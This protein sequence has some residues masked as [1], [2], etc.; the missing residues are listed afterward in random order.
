M[1]KNSVFSPVAA[2]FDN[3]GSGWLSYKIRRENFVGRQNF[4]CVKPLGFRNYAFI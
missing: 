1:F 2:T 3:I 4:G